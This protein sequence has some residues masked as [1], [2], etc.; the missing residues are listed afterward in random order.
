MNMTEA[1]NKVLSAF[2][3]SIV[4]PQKSL[5]D[6]LA[7]ARESLESGRALQTLERFIDVNGK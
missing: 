7:L 6:A 3:I 5:S 1:L 2:A 4:D